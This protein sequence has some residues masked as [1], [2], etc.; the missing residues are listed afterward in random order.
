MCKML[1]KRISFNI[2]KNQNNLIFM[3]LYLKLFHNLILKYKKWLIKKKE[4]NFHKIVYIFSFIFN[5]N[6]SF[7]FIIK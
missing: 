1:L 7:I 3:E 4:A 6:S 5:S 2:L